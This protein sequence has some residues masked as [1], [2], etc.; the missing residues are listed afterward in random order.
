MINLRFAN[1]QRRIKYL[2]RADSHLHK[3]FLSNRLQNSFAVGIVDNGYERFARVNNKIKACHLSSRTLRV[4][5]DLA[6]AAGIS[7]TDHLTVTHE[8]PR[9]PPFESGTAREAL[10][11]VSQKP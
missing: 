8:H 11:I 7:P 3:H 2:S 9:P 10:V 4:S 5:Y 1:A 6:S